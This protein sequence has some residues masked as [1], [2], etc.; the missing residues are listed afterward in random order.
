MRTRA[1]TRPQAL[2]RLVTTCLSC[3]HPAEPPAASVAT[4]LLRRLRPHAHA[5]RV[6]LEALY[7]VDDEWCG[8]MSPMHDNRG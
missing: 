3:G 8:C 1:L 2:G 7:L 6:P 5:C 4:L